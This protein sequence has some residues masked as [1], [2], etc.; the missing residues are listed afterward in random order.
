MK[1]HR[2]CTDHFLIMSLGKVRL[3]EGLNIGGGQSLFYRWSHKT[4]LTHPLNHAEGDIRT[5]LLIVTTD[6]C[7]WIY[8]CREK[9]AQMLFHP[10]WTEKNNLCS[11]TFGLTDS[12]SVFFTN[13]AWSYRMRVILQNVSRCQAEISSPAFRPPWIH[14]E[15]SQSAPGMSLRQTCSRWR[16]LST[17]P[18]LNR[19][20]SS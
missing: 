3:S 13:V 17:Q 2:F 16:I 6:W 14:R 4:F 18:I 9:S 8:L 5:P 19:H 7:R 12:S 10:P 1:Q 11:C 20:L 15:Q